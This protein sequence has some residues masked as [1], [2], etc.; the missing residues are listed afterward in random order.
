MSSYTHWQTF[1]RR[2]GEISMQKVI[3]IFMFT[4]LLNFP[5]L[6]LLAQNSSAELA[7]RLNGDICIVNVDGGEQ[8]C[9]TDTRDVLEQDPVWSPDGRF[10]AYRATVEPVGLG[11]STTYIYDFERESAYELPGGWYVFEWSPDGAFLL[12]IQFDGNDSEIAIV[13][14]DGDNLHLVTS[15]DSPDFAP[16]WSPDGRQI[17]YLTGYPEATLMV[18]DADGENLRALTTDLNINR[19]VR[20]VWRPDSSQIAFVVNGEFINGHQTSEIYVIKADGTDLR[21]WTDAGGVNLDPRWSP[22]GSQIVFW[23]YAVG[24]DDISEPSLSSQVFRIDADGSNLV[25]L[26]QNIG[27][28]RNADWSPDGEWISFSSSRIWE[29]NDFRPGLFIMRPD[30][31]DM[32]MVTNEPS[33]VEGGREPINPVWRPLAG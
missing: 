26:T 11:S 19:E 28:N 10:L 1:R 33:F 17:A 29:S 6:T 24:S 15:N 18:M 2:I 4:T 32:R 3:F 7:F 13:D 5:Q 30:G 8:R 23:G 14:S 25:N 20:P 21:Q 16:A 22:D 31:T 9:L 27:L 12:T